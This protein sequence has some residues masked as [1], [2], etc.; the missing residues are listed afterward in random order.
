MPTT[1][2]LDLRDIHLP[3]AIGWWPPAIGWW[4]LADTL[5]NIRLRLLGDEKPVVAM[6]EV[7]TQ[8][9]F[10]ALRQSLP[11]EQYQA[12]LDHSGRAV[13]AWQQARRPA[14]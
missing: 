5:A 7:A 6:T 11:P 3:E 8:Q 13:V 9:L 14:S 4:L 1:T 10:T 12:I 2:Q